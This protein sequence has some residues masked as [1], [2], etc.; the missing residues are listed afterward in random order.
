MHRCARAAVHAMLC[1][2]AWNEDCIVNAVESELL[3]GGF[4]MTRP[5]R[6]GLEKV[7]MSKVVGPTNEIPTKAARRRRDK[8]LDAALDEALVATFPA[9]DPVALG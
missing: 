5:E 2:C 4:V 9:S 8:R 6:D 1:P 3:C 7:S